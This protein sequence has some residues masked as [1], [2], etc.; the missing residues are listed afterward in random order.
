VADKKLEMPFDMRDAFPDSQKESQDDLTTV[1]FRDAV[2][3][4]A[5]RTIVSISLQIKKSSIDLQSSYQ[6]F[7]VAAYPILRH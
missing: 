3:T 1:S 2:V 7:L 6:C 4:N 5:D